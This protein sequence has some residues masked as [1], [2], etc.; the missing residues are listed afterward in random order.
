MPSSITPPTSPSEGEGEVVA[1]P[2]V[3]KIA[4][5]NSVDLRLVKGTGK[6]GR[7]LKE[8]ILNYMES[9]SPPPPPKVADVI[10]GVGG[11]SGRPSGKVLATPAVRQMAREEGVDL[12]D[13]RGTGEEG[14]VLKEDL[15]HHIDSLRGMYILH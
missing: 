15:Q 14:R 5:E 2:A 3:K 11:A 8:D 1:A 7:I 12:S 13:V 4:N 9:S 6:D 10:T